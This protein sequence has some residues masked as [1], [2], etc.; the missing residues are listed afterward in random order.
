MFS[1]NKQ[2]N[3]WVDMLLFSF[4]NSRW[5]KKTKLKPKYHWALWLLLKWMEIAIKPS[6]SNLRLALWPW[7][8][9]FCWGENQE[10]FLKRW[11]WSSKQTHKNKFTKSNLGIHLP[12]TEYQTDMTTCRPLT[13]GLSTMLMFLNYLSFDEKPCFFLCVPY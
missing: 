8:K 6:Y 3:F 11:N 5:E 12:L 1:Q 7:H 9:F 10:K 13:S 4:R 2:Q